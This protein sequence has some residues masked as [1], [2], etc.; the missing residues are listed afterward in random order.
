[1]AIAATWF[2]SND[3]NS[4]LIKPAIGVSDFLIIILHN[5]YQVISCNA[6]GKIKRVDSNILF[7]K[8]A[9]AVLL[10]D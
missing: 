1:M 8:D 4:A 2:P 10:D 6:F 3:K 7:F 5:D 9:T